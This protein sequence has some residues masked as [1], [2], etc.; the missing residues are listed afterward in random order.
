MPG[1]GLVGTILGLLVLPLAAWVWKIWK[2][3]LAHIAKRLTGIEKAQERIET[4]VD[5]HINDHAKGEFKE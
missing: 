3:D 2:N 5:D 4:K 1:L